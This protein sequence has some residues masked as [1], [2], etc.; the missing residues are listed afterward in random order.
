MTTLDI[1]SDPICPWCY[2]GKARLDAALEIRPD[3]GFTVRWHPFM[4]NPDMP[5]EGMDRLE[6]LSLK[7]G[8]QQQVVAAYLPVQQQA[9]AMSLPLELGRITR[10]PST[11]DAHRLIHW[12]GLE[13]RQ[14]AVVDA[15]FR[16]YF[17]EGADIGDRATLVELAGNAGMEGAMVARLLDTD[18][19]A[20]SIRSRD[21][22]IRARGL[23]GVPAFIIAG[24]HVVPGAQ[25]TP[26]WLRIMDEL[27]G[28]A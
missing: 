26:F 14:G 27:A 12:A 2:I 22:E 10:T 9:D 16:A 13:G 25:D 24:Q 18:A 15:L 3:H 28:R 5:A 19:D 6:Y 7:F 4:L 1:Y 23:Q 20:E 8:N 11:L 21:T 17:T